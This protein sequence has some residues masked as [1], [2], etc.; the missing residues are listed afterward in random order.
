M[1]SNLKSVLGSDMF[2]KLKESIRES[3]KMMLWP[4]C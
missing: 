3:L 4:A 2:G 1:L